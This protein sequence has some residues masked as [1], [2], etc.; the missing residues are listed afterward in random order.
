MTGTI[1][2]QAVVYESLNMLGPGAALKNFVS[3]LARVKTTHIEQLRW[4]NTVTQGVNERASGFTNVN[5][6]ILVD[7]WGGF[8]SFV[9]EFCHAMLLSDTSLR[10]SAQL[11]DISPDPSFSTRSEEDQ[12][13]EILRKAFNKANR[14]RNIVGFEKIRTQLKQVGLSVQGTPELEKRAAYAQQLRHMIVHKR[15][16]ADQTFIDRC[17]Q[18][19]HT[20]GEEVAINTMMLRELLGSLVVY[21]LLIVN[22]DRK[23]KGLDPFRWPI[24]TP[25]AALESPYKHEWGHIHPETGWWPEP[26][27]L[28]YQ[29]YL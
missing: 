11:R 4:H 1:N 20:V 7:A 28:F 14:D 2:F 26:G 22:T 9:E 15:G 13:T 19:A 10:D 24:I 16:I 18:H 27:P 3:K 21:G 8:D 25:D 5:R 29:L 23:Q 6:H 12:A 17:P